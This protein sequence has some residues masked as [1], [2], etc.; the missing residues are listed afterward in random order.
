MGSHSSR[1]STGTSLSIW[2]RSKPTRAAW[3]SFV[4][5][6]EDIAASHGTPPNNSMQRTRQLPSPPHSPL[7]RRPLGDLDRFERRVRM[8]RLTYVGAFWL[9]ASC[10]C[11]ALAC[12]SS[13]SQPRRGSSVS[14]AIELDHVYLYAPAQSTEV[15]VVVA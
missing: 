1:S 4:T 7:T 8:P 14:S 9:V 11:I 12:Q 5:R 2:R 3:W 13:P 6:C 10:A 15:A